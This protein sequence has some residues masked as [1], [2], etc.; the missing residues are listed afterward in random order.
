MAIPVF[1]N[2]P[3]FLTKTAST[4]QIMSL[5]QFNA[6]TEANTFSSSSANCSNTLEA[7]LFRKNIVNSVIRVGGPASALRFFEDLYP[8]EPYDVNTTTVYNHYITDVDYNLY[9]AASASSQG[10]NNDITFQVIKA[11]HS[12][13]G[14][15]SFGEVGHFLFDKDGRV[16]YTI[17]AK[18]DSIPF[19]HKFTVRPWDGVAHTIKQNK[20]YLVAAARPVGGYSCPVPTNAINSLGYVQNVQPVRLRRDW[21]VQFQLMRG[22][23][24]LIQFAVIYDKDGNEMDSWDLF[25]TQVARQD[26]RAALNLYCFIG[27]PALNAGLINNNNIPGTGTTVDSVN[28]GFYG[29]LPSIFNGGG[30]IQDFDPAIGWDLK[31]DWEPLM[32]FQDSLKRSKRFLVMHGKAFKAGMIDR[33]NQLVTRENAGKY[34]WENFK[35]LQ[36]SET[37]QDSFDSVVQKYGLQAYKYLGFGWDFM[38]VDAFSDTRYLGSD[39][40]S[41]LAICAPLDGITIRNRKTP[42]VQFYQHGAE[43]TAGYEEFRTDHRQIDGCE[44][45]SGFCAQSISMAVHGP[46]QFLVANPVSSC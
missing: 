42:A 29:F 43:Y 12:G 16:T 20:G 25:E 8:I 13:Q 6:F 45:L 2:A 4:N 22:Y 36:T 38:E 34:L 26:L 1:S 28:T 14:G 39:Y 27:S 18:D 33:F 9:P 10:P 30:I 15:Y 24:D 31:A 21:S 19:A 35:R 40:Y 44:F 3:R 32:L 17:V 41:N 11:N 46:N 7:A 5:T 37:A 23:Q